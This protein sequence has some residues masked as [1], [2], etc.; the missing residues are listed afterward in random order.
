[1][2]KQEFK[3]AIDAPREKVWNILWTDDSY[4][5]W[6]AP[7]TEGSHAIT[8]WKKGSKVLF[9]D[10]KG[11]GMVSKIDETIPNEYMSFEHLGYVKDG[12]E[13]VTSDEVKSFAGAHENYTLKDLDGRTE[14]IVDMDMNDQYKDYFIQTFPKALAK[15]KELAE[16]A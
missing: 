13:D 1:M 6:T 7:F 5:A 3:I 14:L 8:D 9:L 10:S 12:V 2:E 11:M 15:V 16:L 4:R